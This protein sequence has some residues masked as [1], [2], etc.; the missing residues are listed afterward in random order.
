MRAVWRK[1]LEPDFSWTEG[2][3]GVS[4]IYIC[5]VPTLHP[6]R[7]TTSHS[8]RQTDRLLDWTER[9][10][11]EEETITG[12]QSVLYFLFF[13]PPSGDADDGTIFGCYQIVKLGRVGNLGI[14]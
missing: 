4:G 6:E 11:R 7:L 1:L 13:S 9:G 8:Q 3:T 14:M 10:R 12:R 2:V 5:A